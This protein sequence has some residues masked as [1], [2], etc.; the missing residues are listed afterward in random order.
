[1]I[2]LASS[3]IAGQWIHGA[4]VEDINPFRPSEVV[5]I[6]QHVGVHQVDE[7]LTAARDAESGWAALPAP[8]RGQILHRAAD[9]LRE[10]APELARNLVREEGKTIGEAQ[11]EC[12]RAAA[13]F[14]YFGAQTLEPDG[15]SYPASSTGT[16]LYTRREPLGAV[17]IITPW[18]FPLAIPSWKIAPALAFGNT[19]VWKAADLVPLTSVH[20][21]DV[22]QAAGLPDGVVNLVLGR[23]SVI[24]ERLLGPTIAAV[25]FTGSNLVGRSLQLAAARVGTK[26]QVEMGGHSPAIVLEDADLDLACDQVARGAFLSAGQKCTST[27]R[28]IVDRRVRDR[29]IDGLASVLAP[30]RLGDPLDQATTIG[31]LASG[32]ARDSV[33]REIDLAV[34]AG[35]DLIL[36]GGAPSI[37]GHG[38][39]VEPTVLANVPATV[40]LATEE[41]FGPVLTV[42]TVDGYAEALTVAN[43]SRFGLTAAIFTRDLGRA[44]SF[45]R[46]IRAGVVKVNQETAGLEY[47]VPFG[48]Q[49]ESSGGG[50]E[51]GK[52]AQEFYTE[53]KTVYFRA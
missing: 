46:D 44:T 22:L 19:V 39:F 38:Y 28:V 11:A 4:A 1:M 31:P 21:M 18:N 6:A 45:V 37:A 40:R 52:A 26:I 36:G 50:R 48:G 25:S 17:A 29:F 3:Y 42:Q 14:D 34:A 47:H 41:V 23:G 35:A 49:R 16:H 5:A 10:R 20:L 7:A 33:V 12:A 43:E 8:S 2:P 51:Q 27:R 9:L 24:G 53:T 32:E 30:W 15:H 13:I